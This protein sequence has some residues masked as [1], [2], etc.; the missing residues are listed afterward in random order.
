[1]ID[2]RTAL[3]D[4]L[5]DYVLAHGIGAA[6]LRPMAKAAGTSDRMLLYY[7]PDKDALI[8]AVLTHIAGRL[9]AVFGDPA[10]LEKL[11]LEPLTEKIYSQMISEPVWPYARLWLEMTALA[12][13]GDEKLKAIGGAI[14]RGFLEWGAGQ[15]DCAEADRAGEAARLMIGVEGR[16][17]LKSLGLDDVN[18][19]A[20]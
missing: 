9:M 4:K 6:S 5:S 16:L 17:V 18:A 3:L 19:A 11:P 20:R 10:D 13:S 2:K 15:L 12:A 8:E 7:F 1:M 14:G